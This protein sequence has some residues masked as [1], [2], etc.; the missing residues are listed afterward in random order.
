MLISY[1]P[2]PPLLKDWL[3][4]QELFLCNHSPSY[5]ICLLMAVKSITILLLTRESSPARAGKRDPTYPLFTMCQAFCL[6]TFKHMSDLV[7]VT[8]LNPRWYSQGI[9]RGSN[10]ESSSLV[11]FYILSVADSILFRYICLTFG[12]GPLFIYVC[13]YILI[14]VHAHTHIQSRAT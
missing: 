2:T 13:M 9:P 10:N 6:V 8:S 11:L 1:F 7:S 3:V 4:D 14:Y 12:R 5:S